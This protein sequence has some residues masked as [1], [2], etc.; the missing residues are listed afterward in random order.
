VGNAFAMLEAVL[1][2]A[3]L[4]RRFRFTLLPGEEIVPWATF[5]LRPQHGIPAVVARR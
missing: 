5:T 2:L 4:A 1:V 3:T